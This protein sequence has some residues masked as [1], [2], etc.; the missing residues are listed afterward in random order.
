MRITKINSTFSNLQKPLKP[1]KQKK[2]VLMHKCTEVRHKSIKD[3]SVK[4]IPLIGALVGLITPLP[5]GFLIGYG[6]GKVVELTI[7]AFKKK[8]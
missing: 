2:D 1:I 4:D 5:L 6:L 7:N 8:K 3:M